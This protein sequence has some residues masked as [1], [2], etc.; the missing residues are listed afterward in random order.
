MLVLKKSFHALFVVCLLMND[1]TDMCD[2]VTNYTAD[3]SRPKVSPSHLDPLLSFLVD[4][5]LFKNSSKI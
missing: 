4:S 2:F 3:I 1:K 5:S